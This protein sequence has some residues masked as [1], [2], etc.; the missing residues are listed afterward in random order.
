MR[1]RFVTLTLPLLV[2]AAL[3]AATIPAGAGLSDAE[4]RFCTATN[5]AGQSISSDLSDTSNADTTAEYYRELAKVA[6]KA[7]IKKALKAM[8][9]HYDRFADIDREDADDVGDFLTGNT[10]K[11]FSKASLKVSTYILQTCI[12]GA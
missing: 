2:S 8:A 1:L 7:S 10:Y 4:E 3:I 5:E 9:R 6:P 12:P 11:K